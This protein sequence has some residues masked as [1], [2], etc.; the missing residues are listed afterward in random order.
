[1]LSNEEVADLRDLTW[2]WEGAYD[3]KIVDA[4]W[5]AI[6]A[7]DPAGLLTADSA[8]DLREKVRLDYAARKSAAQAP[9]SDLQERMST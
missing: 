2:H 7:G 3:F 6:P 4:V 9:Q 5:Q 8:W 1:M